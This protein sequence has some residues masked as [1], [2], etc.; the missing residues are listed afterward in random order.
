M[1]CDHCDIEIFDDDNTLSN[2]LMHL[3][4]IH[5]DKIE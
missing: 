3:I 2:Y 1:K 5:G 4:I